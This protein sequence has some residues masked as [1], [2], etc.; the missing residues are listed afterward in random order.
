MTL[1]VG[2]PLVVRGS[3]FDT[4]CVTLSDLGISGYASYDYNALTNASEEYHVG[5]G[6]D[7]DVVVSGGFNW[8]SSS[9]GN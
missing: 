4:T 9:F 8:Q 6:G 2:I 3:S 5:A 7:H 1:F